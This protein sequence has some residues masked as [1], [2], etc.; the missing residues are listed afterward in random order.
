MWAYLL[1]TLFLILLSEH[2]LGDD[3]SRLVTI[4]SNSARISSQSPLSFGSSRNVLHQVFFSRSLT[5]LPPCGLQLIAMLAGR[6]TGRCRM[7]PT[8]LRFLFTLFNK[9]YT[10][11]HTRFQGHHLR[12][13]GGPSPPKEKE[14]KKERR[15]L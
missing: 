7:C 5:L 14:K 9:Q 13:A 3:I 4:F 15:E 11:L 1:K 12:G 6:L 2:I 10:R 8:K